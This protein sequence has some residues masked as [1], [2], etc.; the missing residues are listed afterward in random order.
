MICHYCG[1]EFPEQANVCD[2]CGG[3]L[4]HL[5]RTTIKAAGLHSANSNTDPA[6]ASALRPELLAHLEKWKAGARDFVLSLHL[7]GQNYPLSSL[8]GLK[9]LLRTGLIRPETPVLHRAKGRWFEAH[10]FPG[11]DQ[12]GVLDP[13]STHELEVGD[14]DT[15]AGGVEGRTVLAARLGR[16]A[17]EAATAGDIER[18]IAIYEEVL[19]VNPRYPLVK[20]RL[21]QLRALLA[22]GKEAI[23]S[24]DDDKTSALSLDD[25]VTHAGGD[26]AAIEYGEVAPAKSPTRE[27]LSRATSKQTPPPSALVE[28]VGKTST[29]DLTELHELSYAPT[30]PPTEEAMFSD[31]STAQ[32]EAFDASVSLVME[33]SELRWPDTSEALNRLTQQSLPVVDWRL[34]FSGSQRV[35]F[36]FV[37]SKLVGAARL[38]TD[39]VFHGMICDLCV[40][41]GLLQDTLP[42][43]LCEALLDGIPL[44][45]VLV[46]ADS[47]SLGSLLSRGYTPLL[48][49]QS[50]QPRGHIL[51]VKE[52]KP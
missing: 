40:Q 50:E 18:A 8:E 3:P 34:A 36:A 21:R 47:S 43:S 42:S 49:A 12:E 2:K 10:K 48:G 26:Q 37:G 1:A 13:E 24:S 20:K 33:L 9:E 4:R 19:H 7:L 46:W 14:T 28:E 39:G 6:L 22:G 11:V 5:S 30:N 51:M 25:A 35:C 38:L 32:E 15:A 27:L 29:L 17:E 41:E 23:V 16:E 45:Q 44:K 31:E 52:Q